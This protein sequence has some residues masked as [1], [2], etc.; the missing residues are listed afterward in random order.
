MPRKDRRSGGPD[1]LQ[2][3]PEVLYEAIAVGPG[4]GKDAVVESAPLVACDVPDV[5]ISL[6]LT[7]GLSA[8][9]D[10]YV[11]YRQTGKV[12]LD[13]PFVIAINAGAVPSAHLEQALPMI[14]RAVFP[15]GDEVLHLDASSYTHRPELIKRSGETV[16]T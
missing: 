16:S 13:V 4:D 10:V 11:G 7:S 6:R 14:V 2:R 12:S 9:R 5:E 3:D 15:F 1:L 8:T